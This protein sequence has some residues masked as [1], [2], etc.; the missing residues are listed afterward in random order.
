[1]AEGPVPKPCSHP[2][3]VCPALMAEVSSPAPHGLAVITGPRRRARGQA[4]LPAASS[5]GPRHCE[6]PGPLP[7][8]GHSW[9]TAGAKKLRIQTKGVRA[10]GAF[11]KAIPIPTD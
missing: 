5:T 2:I 10:T 7:P 1:M 6:P 11:L 8:R 4:S 9:T 3:V